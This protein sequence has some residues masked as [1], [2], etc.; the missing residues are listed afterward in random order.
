M[1][2]SV[3]TED[4]IGVQQGKLMMTPKGSQPSSG[5]SRFLVISSPKSYD[6]NVLYFLSNH[7]TGFVSVPG[8]TKKEFRS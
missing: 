7:E 6:K 2:R 1:Q 8:K 5:S 3:T 4:K